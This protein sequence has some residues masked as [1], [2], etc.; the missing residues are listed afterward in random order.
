MRKLKEEKAPEND[1]KL[2]VTELKARKKKLEDKVSV[3][4]Y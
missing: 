2:A 4:I 1:I 3:E